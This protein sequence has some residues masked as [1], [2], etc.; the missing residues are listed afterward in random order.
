MYSIGL[1]RLSNHGNYVS[2]YIC[3]LGVCTNVC[4]EQMYVR[5]MYRNGSGSK[6]TIKITNNAHF[7]KIS[8]AHYNIMGIYRIGWNDNFYID[9]NL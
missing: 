4:I 5:S 6:Y 3:T 2:M 1:E 9:C 7:F 8:L